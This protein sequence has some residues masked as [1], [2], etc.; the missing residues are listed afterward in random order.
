MAL[1]EERRLG[2]LGKDFGD[3]PTFLLLPE[4]TSL[5]AIEVDLMARLLPDAP[6]YARGFIGIAFA[7]TEDG[8]DGVYLRPTNGLS[9]NPPAPR[10]ARAVQYFTWPDWK[11]D[12][13]REVAPDRY[14]AAADI[15]PDRW[16]RLRVECPGNGLR[17][18]VD[19]IDVLALDRRLRVDATGRVGLWVDIGTEGFFRNPRIDSA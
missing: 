11:Y 6:D 5:G 3:E 17:V 10:A 1:E 14:E 2:T 8:F 4:N 18:L 13:L 19:G 12:R 16:H 7:V 9:L 15:G